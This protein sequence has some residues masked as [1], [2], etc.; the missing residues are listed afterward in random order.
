ME[1]PIC[2][3]KLDDNLSI[4]IPC[5]SIAHQFC[6]RCFIELEKRECPLCR[7]SFEQ[8][9]PRIRKQTIDN[10]I[11]FLPLL[12]SQDEKEKSFEI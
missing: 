2:Y 9:V 7:R 6:M 12:A 10:L 5:G 3:E 8:Y 4:S 11:R 1:C